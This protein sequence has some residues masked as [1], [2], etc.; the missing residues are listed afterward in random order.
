MIFEGLGEDESSD[1]FDR[2]VKEMAQPKPKDKAA[3]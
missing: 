1:A 2:I 3:S